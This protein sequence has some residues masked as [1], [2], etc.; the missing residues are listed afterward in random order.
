MNEKLQQEGFR[1]ELVFI[2][3]TLGPF[4]LEDPAK[5]KAGAAFE[6]MRELDAAQAASDWPFVEASVALPLLKAMQEG[7]EDG[8]DAEALVWEYRRLFIGPAI[9]PAPP[10]GSVYTDRD[11]VV[12]GHSTL[13]LRSWM[14]QNGIAR[15]GSDTTPEDHIGL[16]LLLMAWLAENRPELLEDFFRLHLLTWSSHFLEQLAAAT[17][18]PFYRGL[19]GLTQ[20]SLEGIQTAL[21]IRVEY[22]RFYR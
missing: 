14:R 10:W 11:G 2:G 7:L 3:E 5:G 19:A 6:A 20:V 15:L 13:E 17:E 22:P 4:Y 21:H 18:H 12:F 16:L 9:K 8:I 1:D